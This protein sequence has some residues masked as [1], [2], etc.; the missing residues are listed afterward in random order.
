MEPIGFSIISWWFKSRACSAGVRRALPRITLTILAAE[1][2][3]VG[4]VAHFMPW[5]LASILLIIYFGA[6]FGCARENLRDMTL[7]RADQ[8]LAFSP[9]D[10]V[11]DFPCTVWE[12][13]IWL[14]CASAKMLGIRLNPFGMANA[15]AEM[16]LESWWGC[17]TLALQSMATLL[18][19]A[20]ACLA[21]W[22]PLVAFSIL[23]LALSWERA[24]KR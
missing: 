19:T 22:Q 1:A 21:Y 11:L 4:Q 9:R 10:V 14:I 12:T 20:L 17:L 3:A 2:I 24:A 13:V 23:V 5:R 6:G 7:E 15:L 8:Q 16:V 18:A